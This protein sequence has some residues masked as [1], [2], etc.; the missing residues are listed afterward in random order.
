MFSSTV[1]RRL[2]AVIAAAAALVG[3]A[4]CGADG[5]GSPAGT[6]DVIVTAQSWS[7]DTGMITVA[8]RLGF[9]EQEGVSANFSTVKSGTEAVQQLIGGNADVVVATPEPVMIAAQQGADMK[10]FQPFFGRFIYGLAAL[11]GSGITTVADL[12]G[13]RIGV[14]NAASTGATTLRTALR[15]VGLTENDVTLVPIG[16]GAQQITAVRGGDVD[17]LALWDTQ[18]TGLRSQGVSLTELPVAGLDTLFGG[19][20]LASGSALAEDPQTFERFGRAVA[21]TLAWA[22]LHP[23]EALQVLWDALPETRP[24]PGGDQQQVVADQVEYLQTRLGALIP[25]PR[26]SSWTRIPPESVSAFADWAAESGLITEK[27]AVEDVLD[28]GR[29]AAIGDFVPAELKP[30]A[31]P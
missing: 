20:F 23:E 12:R 10:Y 5:P 19:G 16:L 26:S 8:D 27:P 15:T 7:A 30:A 2:G 22:R 25:D 24:A 29:G 31:G 9:L 17:A 21:K 4:G 1:L 28:P 13:K 18:Y 6:L 14:S 3:V 11:D